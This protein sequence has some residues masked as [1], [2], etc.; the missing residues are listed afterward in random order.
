[1]TVEATCAAAQ[2][3]V[4]VF[5]A[6]TANPIY[7][8]S[9]KNRDAPADEPGERH[10]LT[11]SPAAIEAFVRKWDRRHRGTY[12]CVNPLKAGTTRA[13]ANVAELNGLH[14]D[15]DF[16]D[17]EEGPD[18][19]LAAIRSVAL[20]PSMVVSSGNGA[21]AYWFFHEALPATPENVERLERALR[22]LCAHLGGD[23]A[24]CEVSRLM[25]LPGT[26]NTKDGA[27]KEVVVTDTCHA[28]YGL[29][30]LEEW[31][32]DT[33]PIIRRKAAATNGNGAG[34]D[35]LFLDFGEQATKAP[36]DVEAR[37]AAMRHRGVG[38]AAIHTTQL[39]VSASLLSQGVPIAEVVE[40]LLRAT[41]KAAGAEGAF[42]DWKQEESDLW[43]MC[44]AWLAKHP[45]L[46]K[47]S[48]GEE[49]AAAKPK[50]PSRLHCDWV[51]SSEP[52]VSWAVK[53][54]F[55]ETGTGLISGQWGTYK[56]FVL[57]SLAG[58][59]MTG[60]PA[61]GRFPVKRKGGVL[62]IA[63]EG[64]SQVPIRLDAL[65]QKLSPM[66]RLPF[67]WVTE[68]PRLLD[69]NAAKTLCAIAAEAEAALQAEFG[70]PLV[71]IF[72]DTIA[73]AAGYA[74]N[75]ENDAGA[76]QMIVN[77]MATMSR[78]SGA[79]VF[80]LDH[81]GKAVETG[82]RGTSAK[83]SG[84]DVILALLG[85]RTVSGKVT[86]P[87]LCLR[88]VRGGDTGEEI[89]FTTETMQLGT[90]E[91]NEPIT[92]LVI[93]WNDKAVPPKAKAETKAWPKALG[94]FRQSML[95]ALANAGAEQRPMPDGPMVRAVDAEIV[96]SEFYRVYVVVD[97]PPK[98]KQ[99]ARRQAFHRA[100]KDAQ[101]RELIGTHTAG[102]G[103]LLWLTERDNNP[104]TS[105]QCRDTRRRDT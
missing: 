71:A 45:E 101:S 40:Q 93:N 86:N 68:C 24:V 37:L 9:I 59:I 80:G 78:S 89:G 11:R 20:P 79:F 3:I 33:T 100:L 16:K 94:T 90:D 77:A 52:P 83:E 2:F 35:N 75:E 30:E 76:G 48:A 70:L 72:I 105:D 64:Q 60:Q 31:L 38:E 25:R 96:R 46:G 7:L 29:D 69:K 49:D 84:V 14:V 104:P 34:H 57:F 81:F 51:P 39:Q 12:F 58:S 10:V 23:P 47:A 27:W 36:L 19:V 95:N 50:E 26:H 88:K 55:P 62:L 22:R 1:V 32:D 8:S 15:I 21:H 61:F 28:R 43:K 4:D 102:G 18:A 103:T 97:A 53:K 82:T 42:W 5:A 74:P 73:A 6:S 65:R 17:V 44:Y 66:A 92:S 91:D 85:D 13:K 54:V 41:R 99:A 56:T 98:K 63:A 67:V 87:R